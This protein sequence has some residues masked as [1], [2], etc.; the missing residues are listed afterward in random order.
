MAE[1]VLALGVP[2]TPLLWRLLEPEVPDDLKPVA[3]AFAHF[4]NLL[5]AARP[6]TIVLVASDH[7]RQLS[8]ANMPAF[9]VGKDPLMRGTHPNEVRHFGLPECQVPGDPELAR[10]MVGHHEVPPG[11]DFAFSD[12]MWL[13]HAYVVPLLYLTPSLDIPVVPLNT[14]CNA[15]PIPGARR[16][17]ELGAHLR[18]TLEASPL[19]RRVALVASGHLSYELGGPRQFSGGP[20]GPEF[21]ERA[22]EWV[23]SGDV[24]AAL[25]GCTYED[26]LE[27][28]NLTFQFLNFVV[29]MGAAR[30]SPASSV[31]GVVCR[32]GTEPFF[33]WDMA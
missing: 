33:A 9:L 11:F 12:E 27:A 29:C 30:G 5:E 31:E 16:F 3:A 22:L 24:E 18:D 20:S 13:D 23:G 32:F 25:A 17:A 6:D 10:L 28:G 14:N 15:P 26:L 8:T 2:H 19:D 7:F 1:I 21:D 4:R